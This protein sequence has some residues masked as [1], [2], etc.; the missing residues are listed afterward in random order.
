MA[1]IASTV[2]RQL[3]CPVVAMRYPVTDEFAI[4]LADQLY[5][6]LFDLDLTVDAAV[7]HAVAAAAGAQ[8]SPDR[9]A[10]S[11]ATP[12]LLGGVA[13]AGLTLIPPEGEPDLDPRRVR[14]A[15]FPKE[16]ERFVGRAAAMAAATMVLARGSGHT[17]VVFYGMAGAGKTACALELAYRHQTGFTPTFWQAPLTDADPG[18]ALTSLALAMETQLLQ[19][20]F[21]MVD[22]VGS[23]GRLRVFLPRLSQLL[24]DAGVLLV[25]DN[26]ETLLTSD[27]R[28][29][30]Q[31]WADLMTALTGHGGES[32]VV[33]TSRVLPAGLGGRVRVEPVHALSR[34]ESALLARE[35]PG[36]RRLLHADP[37]PVRAV[38]AAV[39]DADR[40]LVRRV[41]AVVQGHPKL[42]EL[43]DAAA[44]DQAVL[45]AHLAA[46]ESATEAA[47]GGAALAAFFATG[48]SRLDPDGF[49][50]VLAGWTASAVGILPGPAGLLVQMLCQLEDE[51]RWS[52]VLEFAWAGVWRRLHPD[53]ATPADAGEPGGSAGTADDQ[54]GDG[55]VAGWAAE[56]ERLVRAALV[57]AE[58]QPGSD[59]DGPPRVRY[60]IHPGVADTIR[61]ATPAPVRV[62]VD[63]ELA[64]FWTALAYSAMWAEGGEH[65][66][67]VVRAGLS[68]APYLLRRHD[69]DQAGRLLEQVIM[70]D[71]TAG[72]VQAALPY[73][74]RIA[75]AT[76]AVEAAVRLANILM[77]VDPAAAER[78]LRDSLDRAVADNNFLSASGTAGDLINLL[79]ETGRLR[80]AL[81]LV[82][83][84]VDY[85]R[86]AGLGPWNQLA[87]QTRRLQILYRLGETARV[88]AEVQQLRVRTADLPD[89]QGPNDTIHPFNVRETI[90][91]LG[92]LAARDLGRWQLAL[93]LTAEQAASVQRRGGGDHAVALT[94]FNAYPSLL[95]LGRLDEADRLLRACQQVFEQSEDIGM[96]AKTLTARAI[97]EARRGHHTQAADLQRAALRLT[98]PRPDPREV[99]VA[100]HSLANRLTATAAPAG[101]VLGHRLAAALL[102]HLTDMA[103]ELTVT[104]R[105]LA[106]DL[107]RYPDSAPPA[108]LAELAAVVEQVDGVRYTIL[109]GALAAD[110]GQID[111]VLAELVAT[112]RTLP[113]DT[114]KDP[115]GEIDRH[116]HRWEPAIAALLAATAG[117]RPAADLLDTVLTEQAQ[118]A[119]WADLVAVLRRILAGDRDPDTLLAGLDP[120]DT[121]ITRRA[122]DALAGRVQLTA[123]PDDL[124]PDRDPG[125]AGVEEFLAAVV[126]AAHGDPA[127]AQAITPVLDAWAGHPDT[128]ALAAA[129][130]RLLAGERHPDRLTTG[131][132]DPATT[133]LQ[134]I[135]DHLPPDA[136]DGLDEAR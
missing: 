64:A 132:D 130:G 9:P 116:L 37:G 14:M 125:E 56:V 102:F 108:S 123:T 72:T 111:V 69:F 54:P 66:P 90:L 136:G 6:G 119:D 104:M 68:A 11:I 133:L 33:L 67:M 84:K 70:R 60:R 21:A 20:G 80:E 107:R 61:E 82:D 19:H 97:L 112:A 77:G 29:R 43:A 95:E 79:M 24:E 51:D 121:A 52:F 122:L 34:D 135:L 12:T 106:E 98:Y 8:P 71:R 53:P 46:A 100:H 83:R 124:T 3:D 103:G 73:L 38:D 115:G 2:A 45:T 27:G 5:Q 91:N 128:A 16:P 23:V 63:T 89:Q 81:D 13:A 74:R 4:T 32:R 85:T 10:I 114:D 1:G 48:Q 110:P 44:A 39:V 117:D 22:K 49:V 113:A 78:L 41:L 96:L 92:A 109:I 65:T 134:T 17:A 40:A 87:N 58:P 31:R 99:G 47:T 86:R 126:A 129:L 35:L 42:L 94:R 75:V 28:W 120:V 7:A 36:L 131:L 62:A 25:L 30:D 93:D 57:H 15:G 50:G 88:L 76:G 105:A 26:L 118:S 101:Q 55:P 18:A 127:A 59:D